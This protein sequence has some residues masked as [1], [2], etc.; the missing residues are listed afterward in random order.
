M[1]LDGGDAARSD[2]IQKG[3]GRM[4]V[5]ARVQEHAVEAVVLGTPQPSDELAFVVGLLAHDGGAARASGLGDG[6]M[7]VRQRRG[8]VD[9]WLPR[10]QSIEIGPGENQDPGFVTSPLRRATGRDATGD[11]T[12]AYESSFSSTGTLVRSMYRAFPMFASGVIEK[13]TKYEPFRMRMMV[14][15]F[16]A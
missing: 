14:M 5:R 11:E 3:D 1:H 4:R 13:A 15:T 12:S 2:G 16:S 10:A 9:G 7:D 8:P 6:S